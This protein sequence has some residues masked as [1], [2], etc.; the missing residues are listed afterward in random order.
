MKVFLVQTP[1]RVDFSPYKLSFRK[2]KVV[3]CTIHKLTCE[4]KQEQIFIS[5]GNVGYIFYFINNTHTHTH[6]HVHLNITSRNIIYV[7]RA[8]KYTCYFLHIIDY[9]ILFLCRLIGRSRSIGNISL[10]CLKNIFITS[11]QFVY[12]YFDGKFHQDHA[13]EQLLEP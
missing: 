9:E 6:T 12:M 13:L 11:H 5:V 7:V 1:S 2:S 3:R 10:L 8:K 4:F